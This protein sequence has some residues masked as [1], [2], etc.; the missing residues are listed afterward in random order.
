M[1]EGLHGGPGFVGVMNHLVDFEHRQAPGFGL[2]VKS[3]LRNGQSRGRFANAPAVEDDV[4]ATL[5]GFVGIAGFDRTGGDVAGMGKLW[6]A[7][8]EAFAVEAH[9]LGERK[10][11][12]AAQFDNIG[13]DVFGAV[14]VG[15]AE[16]LWERANHAC[17]GRDV[18]ALAAVTSRGGADEA[19][20]FVG[21]A[22]GEAVDFWFYHKVRLMAEC[23][24]DFGAE[25]SEFGFGLR[26][27]EAEHRRAVG[28]LGEAIGVVVGDCGWLR[29]CRGFGGERLFK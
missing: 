14:G 21:G 15:G 8:S 7:L 20:V 12:F 5:G 1:S 16:F 29:V 19:A 25:G 10:I 13:D 17:I 26:F 4:E 3:L 9:K 6:F 24:G 27:V 23:G 28:D 18:V 22:D 2:R 11:D